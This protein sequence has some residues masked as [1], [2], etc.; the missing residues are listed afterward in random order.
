[1]VQRRVGKAGWAFEGSL[2]AACLWAA[3]IA[4]PAIGRATPA[5]FASGGWGF[6]AGGLAGLPTV[7]IDETT[8]FLDAG[9]P[10]SA[11]GPMV[12]LIGST[13]I[14]VLAS[15]S[16][17][18]R[19][20]DP[21][22]AGAFSVLVSIRIDDVDGLFDGPFTLL[23]T[24]LVG[25]RGYAPSDVAIELNPSVPASLDTSAVPGFVWNGGFSPFVRVRDFSDAP[26][27]VYDYIGWTVTDGSVVTF[28]YDVLSGL[29]GG[30]YP[31]L[32]ANAVAPVVVPE[33]GTALL[34]GLG[35]TLLASRRMR[36]R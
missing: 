30:F 15:G 23:L 17:V 11:A 18:C 20:A 8:P 2:L 34:F 31:Q 4:A 24:S 33:P 32:T 19:A 7:S 29:R 9:A 28:R 1:M 13:D 22:L 10:G 27:N 16:N 26:A 14:C 3:L 25:G 21:A 12:D 35:L 36:A 5:N 6:A